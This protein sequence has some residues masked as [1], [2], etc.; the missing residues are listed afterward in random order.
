MDMSKFTQESFVSIRYTSK[1][2]RE[3][4][5]SLLLKVNLAKAFLLEK[6]ALPLK[7]TFT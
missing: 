1:Y 3:M 5:S 2:I 6:T 4:M 7:G